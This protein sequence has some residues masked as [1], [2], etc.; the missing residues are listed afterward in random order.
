MFLLSL[1]WLTFVFFSIFL[2]VIFGFWMFY[3]RR[4]EA[5]RS[6]RAISSSFHCNLCG[7]IYVVAGAKAEAPCSNCERS[8]LRLRF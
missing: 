2:S 3:E 6:A 7:Q 8:N 1:D 5:N 4:D